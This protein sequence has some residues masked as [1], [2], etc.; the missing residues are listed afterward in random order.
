MLDATWG[1]VITK[2]HLVSL[3]PYGFICKVKTLPQALL[4]AR[5]KSLACHVL[6]DDRSTIFTVEDD[7]RD[8]EKITVEL[9]RVQVKN[10]NISLRRMRD[11]QRMTW[12][13]AA[14]T[15]GHVGGLRLR[16]PHVQ[17][18]G[19][20]HR[21]FRGRMEAGQTLGERCGPGLRRLYNFGDSSHVQLRHC[22]G[23]IQLCMC[24]V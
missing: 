22:Y 13:L 8:A 12:H 21:R 7:D 10:T 19:G 24:T 3:Q 14:G 2:V 17:N 11:F 9:H 16:S 15:G 20:V 5:V 23:D 4:I 18:I 1:S 6:G